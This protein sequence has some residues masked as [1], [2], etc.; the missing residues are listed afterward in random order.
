M[1]VESTTWSGLYW[2]QP[3]QQGSWSN[4]GGGDILVMV[5]R[6][7]RRRRCRRHRCRHRRSRHH[8]HH[9]HHHH[10]SV[11]SHQSFPLIPSIHLSVHVS[12]PFIH[13][14]IYPSICPPGVF[15][16][17]CVI[18]GDLGNIVW[19]VSK[20]LVR[21]CT[22]VCYLLIEKPHKA[23]QSDWLASEAHHISMNL[24]S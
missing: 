12:N 14:P 24:I 18:L 1:S 3:H 8:H 22:K 15:P 19:F 11:L 17:L 6:L 20:Y 16:S 5:C 23:H 13:P 2:R 10:P 9:H 21:L 4:G 7:R